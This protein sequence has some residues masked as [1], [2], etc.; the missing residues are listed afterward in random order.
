MTRSTTLFSLAL[1]VCTVLSSPNKLPAISQT[2]SLASISRQTRRDRTPIEDELLLKLAANGARLGRQLRR[3]P[4]FVEP[5]SNLVHSIP[6]LSQELQEIRERLSRR[7]ARRVRGAARRALIREEDI[8]FAQVFLTGLRVDDLVREAMRI[9]GILRTLDRQLEL[10]VL[11]I[12][13]RFG[14]FPVFH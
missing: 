10:A 13:A 2:S 14:T 12:R 8:L 11:I 6:V 5:L 1:L 3:R 4:F 9:H 7:G